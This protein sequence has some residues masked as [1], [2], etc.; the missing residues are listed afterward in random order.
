MSK[1]HYQVTYKR[2][3]VDKTLYHP[4]TCTWEAAVPKYS[5]QLK[6]LSFCWAVMRCVL[7]QWGLRAVDCNENLGENFFFLFAECSVQ[8][9]LFLVPVQLKRPDMA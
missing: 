8:P 6:L 7:N 5:L 2:E 3:V 4:N 9:I 1:P